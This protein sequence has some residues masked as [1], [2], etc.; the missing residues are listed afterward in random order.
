M[1]DDSV[2]TATVKS[3]LLADPHV[4]RLDM[5][6]KT[7]R[8]KVQLSGYVDTQ[9]QID[10][11]ISLTRAVSGVKGIKIVFGPKGKTTMA[12]NQSDDFTGTAKI[13]P[14]LLANASGRSFAAAVIP[15][16]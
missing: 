7:R 8:G 4:N 9:V 6:V 1:I 15:K 12:V 5:R 14:T 2:I 11:L 10:R 16:D 3:A 13:T